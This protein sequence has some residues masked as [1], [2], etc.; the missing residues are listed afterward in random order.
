MK[1]TNSQERA[2]ASFEIESLVD[3]DIA[4]RLETV[5]STNVDEMKLYEQRVLGRKLNADWKSSL[6]LFGASALGLR[7]LDG[8]RRLGIEPVAFADNKIA[9]WDTKLSGLDVL[10]PDEA[11]RRF[12]RTMNFIVCVWRSDEVMTQLKELGCQ[13]A[14]EFKGLFWHYPSEFLPNMRVDLPHLILQEAQ[15]VRDA[16]SLL[17]D[18]SSRLEYVRQIEWL[19]KYDF[20]LLDTTKHREQYFEDQLFSP[21]AEEV[22]VDCGAYTGDTLQTFLRRCARPRALHALEPEPSNLAA[23]RAWR[24]QQPIALR[25][26]IFVHGFAASD[27]RQILRFKVDGVGS[28]IDDRGGVEV[29]AVS[30]NELLAGETVTFIKMDIEGGE[31]AAIDGASQ[32]ISLCRPVLAICLYHRQEHLFTIPNKVNRISDGYSFF[33][34]RYGDQFGDVVCY[35]VPRERIF[36]SLENP[37]K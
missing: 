17:S 15:A 31:A 27:R 37:P 19:L 32:L 2:P 23:L 14:L 1:F 4:Q 28:A 26:R 16:F 30:L 20:D 18:R 6:I 36:P 10:S 9:K 35:G 12:G 33:I 25:D 34:R 5:L 22:F 21:H 29:E 24:D 3:A 13:Y 8:L 11:L 7:T